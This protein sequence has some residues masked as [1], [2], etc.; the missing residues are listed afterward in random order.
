MSEPERKEEK[1]APSQARQDRMKEIDALYRSQI[2]Q[3]YSESKDAVAKQEAEVKKPID[4]LLQKS[5]ESKLLPHSTMQSPSRINKGLT[6]VKSSSNIPISESTNSKY[7]NFQEGDEKVRAST[8]LRGESTR[9]IEILR[10]ENETKELKIRELTNRCEGLIDKL[11]KYVEPGELENELDS[12]REFSDSK[13]ERLENLFKIKNE[14]IFFKIKLQTISLLQEFGV[15]KDQLSDI[16]DVANETSLFSYMT[17]KLK[18]RLKDFRSK[19]QES[20]FEI[21]KDKIL[22]QKQDERI[23]Y[24]TET[25]ELLRLS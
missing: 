22:S 1:K 10:K 17:R 16:N 5:P 7:F 18:G 9:T 21:Q 15:G 14:E 11:K 6:H 8:F 20:T 19:E 4:S 12:L 25:N 2:K 3:I 13:V 23:H 24:L